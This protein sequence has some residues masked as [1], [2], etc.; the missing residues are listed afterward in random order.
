MVYD[1]VNDKFYVPQPFASW[2]LNQT[3]W[4]WDAPLTDPSTDGAFL[5]ME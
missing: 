4:D 2:T 5:F 1:S 3:T